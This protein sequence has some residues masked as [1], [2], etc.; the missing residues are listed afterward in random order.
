[1]ELLRIRPLLSSRH[2]RRAERALANLAT[3]LEMLHAYLVRGL[4]AAAEAMTEAWR[5]NARAIEGRTDAPDDAAS[6]VTMHSAKGLEWPIVIPINC[7][8]LDKGTKQ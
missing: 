4:R 2:R 1:M 3:Y 6:I 5:D 7:I 8:E